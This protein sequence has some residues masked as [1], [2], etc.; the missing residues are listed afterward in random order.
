MKSEDSLPR[1]QLIGGE[2][3]NPAKAGDEVSFGDFEFKNGEVAQFRIHRG[4]R[5]AL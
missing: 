4:V 1:L 5:M 2:G 3:L